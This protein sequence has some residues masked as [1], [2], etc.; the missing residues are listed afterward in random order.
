M[1][2][3]DIYSHPPLGYRVFDIVEYKKKELGLNCW[4]SHAYPS[5][6]RADPHT[7]GKEER[8]DHSALLVIFQRTNK[9]RYK[10][11]EEYGSARFATRLHAAASFTPLRSTR[12]GFVRTGTRG[13]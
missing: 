4:F 2:L 8:K 10:D 11:N 13:I 9:V 1:V 3:S 5:D 7:F 12:A 6:F